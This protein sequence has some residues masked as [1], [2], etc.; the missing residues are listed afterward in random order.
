MVSGFSRHQADPDPDENTIRESD[1]LDVRFLHL[2]MTRKA[3]GASNR[4]LATCRGSAG[5]YDSCERKGTWKLENRI[6][7]VSLVGLGCNNFGWRLKLRHLSRRRRGG[8]TPGSTFWIPLTSLRGHEEARSSSQGSGGEAGSGRPRTKFG[9][10]VDDARQGAKPAYVRQAAEDSLRLLA[11]D[12][13]DSISSQPDPRPPSRIFSR[14]GRAGE[15][16][17]GAGDRCSN[18]SVAQLR[19]AE[20]RSWKAGALCERSEPVQPPPS[21]AGGRSPPECE[22]LKLAFLPSSPWRAV[23]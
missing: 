15:E 17:Q 1:A 5:G 20:R 6:A 22:R 7:H 19:E 3:S 14:H 21:R 12:H 13:I 16:R 10:K 11:T 8:S 9:M 23:F 2:R 4:R 18:F